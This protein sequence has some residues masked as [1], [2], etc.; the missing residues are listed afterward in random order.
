MG[1]WYHFVQGTL[2]NHISDATR[3]NWDSLQISAIFLNISNI[4]EITFCNDDFGV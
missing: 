2:R 1:E 4:S 3:K